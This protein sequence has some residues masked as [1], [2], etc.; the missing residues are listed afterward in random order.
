MSVMDNI[1]NLFGN[2]QSYAKQ[3]GHIG[4]LA[5]PFLGPLPSA[6]GYLVG[7]LRD[8]FSP[9]SQPPTGPQA[10]QSD[11]QALSDKGYNMQQAQNDSTT[12]AINNQGVS[13]APAHAPAMNPYS[14]PNNP[15]SGFGLGWNT[16]SMSD[17]NEMIRAGSGHFGNP[18]SPRHMNDLLT[19]PDGTM[20][21]LND[22]A[23][24]ARRAAR[25]GQNSQT[26]ANALTAYKNRNMN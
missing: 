13:L 25:Y 14:N 11:L 16:A 7:A 26:L 10:S 20:I 18:V 17:I 9:R 22:P 24:Q 3:Y 23:V 1:H 21:D 12:N 19:R 6:A 5:S 4:T 15:T 8:H 2:D